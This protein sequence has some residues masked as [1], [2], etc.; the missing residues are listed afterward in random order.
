MSRVRFVRKSVA[1]TRRARDEHRRRESSTD[2]GFRGQSDDWCTSRIP[3]VFPF[4]RF[5]NSMEI[6]FWF[7]NMTGV[8]LQCQVSF[9]FF[10]CF[11][12]S[13][14][15]WESTKK[16]HAAAPPSAPEWNHGCDP[17]AVPHLPPPRDSMPGGMGRKGC[18][19]CG[20]AEIY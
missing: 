7:K 8:L 3:S 13:Q 2:L 19:P 15:A 17:I 18:L 20:A 6:Q 16:P 11:P 5:L 9:P 1:T 4:F 10:R 14:T 12:F